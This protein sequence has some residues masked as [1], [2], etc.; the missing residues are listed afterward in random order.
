VQGRDLV[1]EGEEVVFV[2]APDP[3]RG[4]LPGGDRRANPV[5]QHHRAEANSNAHEHK[6]LIEGSKH[7]SVT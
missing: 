6:R 7:Q 1:V 4:G 3:V 2:H 5:G